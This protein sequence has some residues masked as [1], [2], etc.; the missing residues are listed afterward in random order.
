MRTV[1]Q[2]TRA[3]GEPAGMVEVHLRGMAAGHLSKLSF[4]AAA[5][6][7]HPLEQESLE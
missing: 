2:R 4:A 6:T 3:A 7:L 5:D 1:R